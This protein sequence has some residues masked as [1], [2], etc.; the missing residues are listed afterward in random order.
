MIISG[1]IALDP[2]AHAATTAAVR[3]R[4]EH[5]EERRRAAELSVERVLTTWR[6]DAAELFRTRWEEWNRGALAVIDQLSVAADG[7]DH[8]RRSL[9][10]TDAESEQSTVRLT[11]R[12][13]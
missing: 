2:A 8:A 6:G 12:L 4:L 13:G 3:L 5:L 7:L 11:G 10:A 9:A 1:T